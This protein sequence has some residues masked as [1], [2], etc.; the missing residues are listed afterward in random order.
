MLGAMC[1]AVPAP[2]DRPWTRTPA[3]PLAAEGIV[4]VWQADLAAAGGL[5][6]LLDAA[7]ECA[8]GT[9]RA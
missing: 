6:E 2:T 3:H 8:R 5:E 1:A 7:G 4:H 9:D